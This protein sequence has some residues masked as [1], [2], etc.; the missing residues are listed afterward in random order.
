MY[1]THKLQIIV[2]L[3]ILDKAQNNHSWEEMT[4]VVANN[5]IDIKHNMKDIIWYWKMKQ[6]IYNTNGERRVPTW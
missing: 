1:T 3:S 4:G 2:S 5:G 6:I